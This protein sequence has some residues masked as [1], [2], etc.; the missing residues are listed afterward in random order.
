VELQIH[1][2]SNAIVVPSEAIISEMEGAKV[3]LYKSGKAMPQSITL[4]MRT[5]T[6]VHITQGLRSGD[7][8]ITSG[9]LQLR[10]GMA[11]TIN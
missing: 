1:L 7:T 6:E 3:F 9:M 10:Y 11:V 8:I 4:G 5:E 2:F